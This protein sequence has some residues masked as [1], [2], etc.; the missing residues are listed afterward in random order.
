[1]VSYKEKILAFRKSKKLTQTQFAKEL[2]VSRS[3]VAQIEGGVIEPSGAFL[4][5]IIQKFSA[6]KKYFFKD[7]N[8]DI[9]VDYVAENVHLIS[10]PTVHLFEDLDL[11]YQQM[12]D[13]FNS[14]QKKMDNLYQRLIDIKLMVNKQSN[15]EIEQDLN[16]FIDRFAVIRN[17]YFNDI[18]YNRSGF[19]YYKDL[20]VIDFIKLNKKQL[21]EYHSKFQVDLT[22]FEFVF[23]DYFRKF[24]NEYMKDWYR[25]NNKK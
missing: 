6:N 24:Y 17:N 9:N 19:I 2:E 21:N 1:M 13:I 12:I 3:Y 18:T 20:E 22:L 8:N 11:N 25:S 14:Y 5:K 7:D 4:E 16:G 10:Y 23:F 15:L